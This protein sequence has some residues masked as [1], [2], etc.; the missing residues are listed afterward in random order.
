M[1]PAVLDNEGS[2]TN[3]SVHSRVEECTILCAGWLFVLMKTKT[4]LDTLMEIERTLLR[5]ECGAAYG[6]ILAAQDC[7]L[8][9]ERELIQLETD[10]L[11][12]SGLLDS[13]EE[14]KPRTQPVERGLKQK[15]IF[16][17]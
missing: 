11:R 4:L 13:D 17:G 1:H 9:I 10:K 2:H 5:G 12:L 14:T 15:S 3:G 8:E 16:R 6:L 7:V